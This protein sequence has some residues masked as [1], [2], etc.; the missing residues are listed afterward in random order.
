MKNR[1]P[2]QEGYILP[3]VMLVLLAVGMM[4]TVLLAAITTNQ[5]HVA[6]DRAFTQSLAVAEAGLNQY[7]WMVASG[8][9]SDAN[10]F[11]IPDNPEPDVHKQTIQLT[12]IDADVK[13]TYTI[14]VIPPSGQDSR[15]AVKV[16]GEAESPT[17]VPRTVSAHI[18]RPS[19][20][21]YI[22]LV[23]ESVYIGGPLDRVWHGKTHSNTGIRIETRDIIDTVSC[24]RQSYTYDAS[25]K[26]GIWSSD[27]PYGDASRALWKFPVPKIDFNTVTSDFLR[28]D[29]KAT[30]IHNLP[31]VQ[32]TTPGAAHGWYIK[33]LPGARYQVAEVTKEY[34]SRSYSSGNN[35]GGYLTFLSLS[36][37]RDYPSNG[38]IY[39]NDNVW[40]EGTDLDGRITIACSGQLN[41][42]GK[43]QATCINIVGDLTYSTKDGSVAVGLIAENDVKIPMYAPMGKAGSLSTMDMEVDAAIIAQEGAEYVSRDSSGSS[44]QWGPRRDLLTFYGS[45]SSHD[46]PTRATFPEY[47]SDYCGFKNGANV[48]DPFLLYNPPPYFPTVGS[49]QILDWRELPLS[50]AVAAAP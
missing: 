9:S 30:G 23:D 20:S 47:G 48:Y 25:T 45:I 24:A 34:E 35:R 26:P 36:T 5:Q 13:G 19:F 37:V 46:T 39:A 4:G 44:S 22:L 6:R 33:L 12:D 17:E 27:V 32:P 42:P 8:A 43:T 28:L 1:T 41:P 21:E 16:T 14:Q 29:A 15:I 7:L 2:G 10:D 40:V 3:L 49:F 31:Y 38:V 50:E 11:G 18:G